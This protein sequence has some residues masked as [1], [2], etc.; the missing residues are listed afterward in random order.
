MEPNPREVIGGNNPPKDRT[1]KKRWAIA[2]FAR[3]DKPA[4]AVAMGFKLYMEMDSQG[5]GA[6]ISDAEFQVACGVSDGSCRVFKRWLVNNGFVQVR[7]RGRRGYRSEFLAT[8]PEGAIPAAIAGIEAEE[9][10]QPIPAEKLNG[11]AKLPATTAAIPPQDAPA[12]APTHARIEPPSGVNI[13]QEA[14]QQASGLAGLNGSAEPMIC[15]VLA[16]MGSGTEF[17]ARQWLSTFIQQF[18]QDVVRNSYMKLKTDLLSGNLIAKPLQTWS[19]I[20]QRMKAE[21]PRREDHAEAP[22]E[23]RRDRIRRHIEKAQSHQKGV[24]HE[25]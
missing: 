10:R 6:T 4:G 12:S 24:R 13:P 14:S 17:N 2:L 18:G 25:P 5:H 8:I 23:T 22:K 20:A 21:P 19:K 15:D 11:G 1:F 7:V 16:W 9:Y 3:Q